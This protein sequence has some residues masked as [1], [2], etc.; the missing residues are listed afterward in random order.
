MVVDREVVGEEVVAESA[1]P[2]EGVTRMTGLTTI[3]GAAIALMARV[4]PITMR[5]IPRTDPSRRHVPRV[6][7]L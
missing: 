6:R 2:M 5:E 4:I 7:P 3:R 1:L